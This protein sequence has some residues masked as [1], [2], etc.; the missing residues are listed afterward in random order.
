M[1]TPLVTIDGFPRDDIDVLQ[2]MYLCCLWCF[3][4]L[5]LCI[6]INQS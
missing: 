1:N 2:S 4:L 6:Y 3:L 5:L